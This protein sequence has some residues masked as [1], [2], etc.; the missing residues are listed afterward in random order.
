MVNS[1]LIYYLLFET[2]SSEWTDFSSIIVYFYISYRNS[3]SNFLSKS[4]H[5]Y[6]FSSIDNIGIVYSSI[7]STSVLNAVYIEPARCLSSF[8]SMLLYFV[9]ENLFNV[10]ATLANNLFL[11]YPVRVLLYSYTFVENILIYY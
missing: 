11:I 10:E 3:S 5:Y 8:I 1:L 7:S 6:L 4:S 9:S 2:E